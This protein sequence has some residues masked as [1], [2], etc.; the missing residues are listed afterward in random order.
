MDEKIKSINIEPE[1]PLQKSRKRDLFSSLMPAA[2]IVYITISALLLFGGYA[3]GHD[4]LYYWDWSRHLS[5]AYYDGPPGVAY[6]LR[7]FTNILGSSQRTIVGIGLLSHALIGFMLYYFARS[8]FDRK[9]ASLTTV[10]WLFSPASFSIYGLQVTYD[11][12]TCLS[13]LATLFLFYK[14]H[15]TKRSFYLYFSAIC[16]T[17]MMLSKFTGV[18]IFLSL[19][20]LI[21][22]SKKYRY[23]LKNKHLY[24]SFSLSLILFS[25]VFLWN[26]FH[27]TSSLTYQTAHV[28]H[29]RFNITSFLQYIV[30]SLVNYNV[31]F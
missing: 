23:L 19:L 30:L 7:F 1:I 6:Y 13:A 22:L 14:F 4:T 16:G 3:P 11:T 9:V 20:L 10:I 31:I 15:S 21:I 24:F 18:S 12:P 28:F 17:L 26:T 29:N 8:L 2:L 5:L 25:L 27:E